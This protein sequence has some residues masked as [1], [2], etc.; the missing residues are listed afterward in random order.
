MLT[1]ESDYGGED[2]GVPVVILSQGRFL[3]ANHAIR[4]YALKLLHLA[5]RPMDFDQIYR[6][7][8]A[9]SEVHWAG[10]G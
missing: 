2:V 3:Y 4:H 8:G 1:P 10:T 5:R 6:R 7:I 9:Q